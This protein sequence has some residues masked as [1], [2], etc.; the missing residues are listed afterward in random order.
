MAGRDGPRNAPDGFL[1]IV[2]RF[3]AM[4]VRVHL[5]LPFLDVQFC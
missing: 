2:D 1:G 3:P 4:Q 5:R